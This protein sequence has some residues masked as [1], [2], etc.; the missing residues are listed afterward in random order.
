VTANRRLTLPDPG[1]ILTMRARDSNPRPPPGLR[2]Y[3]AGSGGS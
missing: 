2:N 1:G 3:P